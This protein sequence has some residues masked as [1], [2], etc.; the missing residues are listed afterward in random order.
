MKLKD[1]KKVLQ[2]WK[3]DNIFIYDDNFDQNHYY[4][5]YTSLYNKKGAIYFLLKKENSGLENLKA[6]LEPTNKSLTIKDIDD[7]NEC[8][9]QF[10]LFINKNSSDILK[11][12]NTLDKDIIQKFVNFS[13]HYLSIF[14]L[15]KIK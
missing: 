15:D 13:N 6:K 11:H 2:I 4:E 8:S 7:A 9:N 14:G 10:K 1:L 5:L 12:I 3:D